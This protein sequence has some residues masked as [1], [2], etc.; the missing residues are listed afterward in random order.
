MLQREEVELLRLLDFNEGDILLLRKGRKG[1]VIRNNGRSV[2]LDI[3][4]QVEQHCAH[5]KCVK[6]IL[7]AGPETT[8]EIVRRK[9]REMRANA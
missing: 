7:K 2:Q 6:R 9:K 5:Y 8:R 4:G 3:D 1:K